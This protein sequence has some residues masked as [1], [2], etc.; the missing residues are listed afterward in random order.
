MVNAAKTYAQWQFLRFGDRTLETGFGFCLPLF[1]VW[2]LRLNSAADCLSFGEYTLLGW[3]A[4]HGDHGKAAGH[5]CDQGAT[6]GCLDWRCN[7]TPVFHRQERGGAP[8][9]RCRPARTAW[10]GKETV[11]RVSTVLW[12]EQAQADLAAIQSS[13]EAPKRTLRVKITSCPRCARLSSWSR[14]TAGVRSWFEEAIASSSI[15]SSQVA[16]RSLVIHLMT[17]RQVPTTASWSRRDSRDNDASISDRHRA[18]RQQLFCVFAGS[19]WMRRDRRDTRRNGTPD[20]RSHTAPRWG[21]GRGQPAGSIVYVVRGIRRRAGLSSSAQAQ[22]VCVWRGTKTQCQAFAWAVEVIQRLGVE[23]RARLAVAASSAR[24]PPTTADQV[25]MPI[26]DRGPK[27]RCVMFSK[28]Y[29]SLLLN[30]R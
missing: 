4:S 10:R 15:Q 29:C 21:L 20:V 19:S 22:H 16:S 17:W 3:R 5:W 28:F 11:R 7:R 18:S 27:A 6:G 12:T 1:K 9:I 2:P 8:A 13:F 24:R 23:C 25:A 14:L 26:P 30:E